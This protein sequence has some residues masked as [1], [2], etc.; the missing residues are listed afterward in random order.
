M[1]EEGTPTDDQLW[2]QTGKDQA[3]TTAETVVDP[4]VVVQ[5]SDPMAGLPEP[6][7]KL[8]EGLNTTVAEQTKRLHTVGQQLATAHGTMGNMKQQLDASRGMLEKIAPTI[9]FVEADK[10]DAEKTAAD[11]AARKRSELR[12]RLADFPDVLEY[13]DAVLPADAKPAEVVKPVDTKA[14]ESTDPDTVRLLTLQ[15]ELS[16]EVPGWMKIRDSAEFKAWLPAQNEQ[17][18]AAAGSWDVAEA[19]S[20]FTAFNKHK[21]D[22]A[23]VALVEKDRQDRLRRGEG[24]QGR[25]TSSNAVDTSDDALWKQT[26]IDHAKARAA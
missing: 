8:I 14:V 3:S 7:R 5:E 6:T 10:K 18:K 1:A 2:D 13:L 21:T 4:S 24:V 17:V 15:R 26:G 16:D 9:A 23:R 25:G 11:T 19:A 20:V 12:E 22:A